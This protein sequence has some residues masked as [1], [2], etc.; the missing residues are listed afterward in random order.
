MQNRFSDNFSGDLSGG[1]LGISGFYNK[2]RTVGQGNQAWVLMTIIGLLS[3]G[4][5]GSRLGYLQLNQGV[6]NR[7]IA[8]NNRVRTVAKPPVRGNIYDRKGRLLAGNKLSHSVFIWPLALKRENWLKT[9]REVA[10]IL[11]LDEDTIQQK[12]TG[13][14]VNSTNRVRIVRDLTTAQITRLKEYGAEKE[15]ID[16]DIESVRYYPG[17][18]LAAHV[19]GYTGEMNDRELAKRR[20]M[21]YRLGDVTGKMGL[22]ST[23]EDRLRGEWGGTQVEVDGAGRLQQFLGQKVSKPGQDVTITIDRD[24]QKVAED[25]L[26]TH[27]AALIAMD[28]H[29]GEILAM[30]SRPAFDP[31]SLSG[32]ISPAVWKE[33]QG[34]D[35]PFVNRALSVF[36]P[37]STF[38]IVTTTAALESGKF[39]PDA[40]LQ[41]YASL[42][43]GGF[44]FSDWNHAGFGAIGFPGAMK[45][46]S[47]TFFGQ[48]G[49]RV[50]GETLIDWARKYGFGKKTGIELPEERKGL[51]SDDNWKQLN[52]KIPWSIG[53][54]INMSIGQ[55]FLQTSPLQVAGMFAVPANGGYHV[56][57][58]L[59]KDATKR[60]RRQ[61]MNLKP[62]TIATLRKGLR[63]VV[64]GGTGGALN[65][66]TIPPASG[67]SGTAEAPPGENH[68]WFGGYAPVDKPEIVVVAFGEHTGGGGGKTAAPMVLKV[69]EAYFNGGKPL[70]TTEKDKEKATSQP[71]RN[72][73][74]ARRR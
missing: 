38:K 57:P 40:I 39:K 35:H 13:T 9:R 43:I 2:T 41:T 63:Q 21:G 69:M 33:L 59:L 46:S 15:G 44:T 12:M 26:G 73:T 42:R 70:P 24:L 22:E 66:K 36:P 20:S 58:H 52:Y 28:P 68:V 14:S 53:D 11:A 48:V 7:Q 61:S 74:R 17:G 60:E 3:L 50:G 5:I 27:K 72:R 62:S 37:A 34:K 47:N 51:V 4:A 31:N 30:A 18:Q 16:V 54:T 10:Q 49:Q 65:V 32:R 56:Q 19:L 29:T 8:E 25:A 23:L 45:W 64:D 55:G 67:K 6:K 1:D 71:V